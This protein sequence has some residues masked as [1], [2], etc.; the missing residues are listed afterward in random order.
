VNALLHPPAHPTFRP[1]IR[2]RL[3]A[4]IAPQRE[5]LVN[6]IAALCRPALRAAGPPVIVDQLSLESVAVEPALH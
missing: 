3:G 5:R 2:R 1:A 4:P 6:A